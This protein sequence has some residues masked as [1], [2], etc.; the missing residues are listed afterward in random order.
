[1]TFN[2]SNFYTSKSW[3]DFR[4][5]YLAEKIKEDGEL[6]DEE[7]GK[8]I[9]EKGKATLHHIIPLTED[10]VNDVNISLNPKNIKLVSSETHSLIHQKF[11]NNL[12]KIYITKEEK[13][14]NIKFDLVVSFEKLK[15]ALGNSENIK[16]NIWKVYYNL[17]DQL[18]TCYGQWT[19]ALVVC[20]D[21]LEYKRLKKR[22]GAEEV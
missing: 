9:L 10:N 21:D 7:T 20:I 3:Q 8:P 19:T 18:F 15:L 2:L 13:N 11:T 4:K 6:I 5:L 22:L 14:L 17:I 16:F 1:M 12:K